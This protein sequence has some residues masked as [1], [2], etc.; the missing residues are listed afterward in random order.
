M[1]DEV[2]VSHVTIENKK[3]MFVCYIQ[4]CEIKFHNSHFDKV[5]PFK[6]KFL[7]SCLEQI[8]TILM[9]CLYV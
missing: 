3:R 9:H 4:F 6:G 8:L 5:P 7:L 1:A 2:D